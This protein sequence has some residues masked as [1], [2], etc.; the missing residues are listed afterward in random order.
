LGEV[1]REKDIAERETEAG[2]KWRH[3]NL[4]ANRN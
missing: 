2:L 4:P 3:K 1:G